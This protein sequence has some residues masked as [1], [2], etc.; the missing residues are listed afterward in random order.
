MITKEIF[1]DQGSLS[2][3]L[4]IR[5]DSNLTNK[6]DNFMSKKDGQDGALPF[7][8][9]MVA[10]SFAEERISPASFTSGPAFYRDGNSGSLWIRA[11]S[12]PYGNGFFII[13]GIPVNI[14][15][16]IGTLHTL[17]GVKPDYSIGFANRRVSG[18]DQLAD[19]TNLWG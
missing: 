9:V 4:E 17:K 15:N 16:Y 19:F 12:H 13:G 3:D 1:G 14:I 8:D 10:A 5:A 18:N 11:G 6:E 2:N 7:A